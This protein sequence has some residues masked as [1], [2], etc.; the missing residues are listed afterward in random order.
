MHQQLMEHIIPPP[1]RHQRHAERV[2]ARAAHH[3]TRRAHEII[4][5]S[6]EQEA[7]HLQ[8]DVLD[9]L[10]AQLMLLQLVGEPTQLLNALLDRVAPLGGHQATLI[11]HFEPELTSE[12]AAA[13]PV[14]PVAS[15][16]VTPAPLVFML[17]RVAAQPQHERRVELSNRQLAHRADWLVAQQPLL[18][19]FTGPLL[20]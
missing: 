15:K 7:R 1:A 3:V 12:R 5:R 11:E 10:L 9:V 16:C 6:L 2:P 17:R 4:A 18:H 14:E 20:L 19:C 13:A 8:L